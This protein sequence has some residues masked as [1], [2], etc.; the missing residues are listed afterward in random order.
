MKGFKSPKLNI[1]NYMLKGLL[2]DT[3][4][5]V[6]WLANTFMPILVLVSEFVVAVFF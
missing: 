3:L 4:I 1:R 2:V 5:Y 6:K